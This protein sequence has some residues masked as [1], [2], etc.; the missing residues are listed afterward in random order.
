VSEEKNV[1]VTPVEHGGPPRRSRNLE[2]RLMVRFPSLYRRQGVLLQRLLSPRSRLRRAFLRRAFVSGYT[3]FNRGDFK[4]MLVRVAPD[5]EVV[6][7]PGMQTLGLGG[8][9]RGHAGWVESYGKL[10]EVW[11]FQ[12][13]EPAY[14]VDLGERLLCL[15]FLR[16]H[17]RAS[18]VP[19]EQEFA[20]LA[21]APEGLITHE[22]TFFS[23]G[24][25][26]RAAGLDPSAIT[27]PSREKGAQTAGSAG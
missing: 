16:S 1:V 8:V 14:I 17:A 27:L 15:S 13:L 23:W 20:Q 24:E 12:E 21:T 26:L 2:E 19:L 22:Q 11:D 9:F 7:P 5:V 25:G 3:A 6:Y 10:A 18:G 4:L